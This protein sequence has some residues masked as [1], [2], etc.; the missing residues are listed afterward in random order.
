M[1]LLCGDASGRAH[2]VSLTER[3]EHSLG[4]LAWHG[5][6]ADAQAGAIRALIRMVKTFADDR[7]ALWRSPIVGL[8]SDHRDDRFRYFVGVAVEPDETLPDGF[9]RRHLVAGTYA[10]SWHGP[11]DG[12]VPE[13]YGRMIEW[14][15]GSGWRWDRSVTQHR[16][17]YPPDHDPDATAPSLRLLLPVA[18]DTAFD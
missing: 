3:P 9:E 6:H 17:E 13:H 1:C 10:G 16:E 14:L 11:G 8:S 2:S 4:G 12:A 7:K 5:S 15:V 18:R